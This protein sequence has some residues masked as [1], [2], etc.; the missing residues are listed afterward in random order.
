[1]K[2]THVLTSLVCLLFITACSNFTVDSDYTPET[3]FDA[4]KTYS[5]Y[6]AKLRDPQSLD[7]LGGDIFDKRVRYNID[8]QLQAKGFVLKTEGE[9]DFKVNYDVLT[10]DRQDIRTYNTYGGMAPG[11][12]YHGGYGYGGMNMGMGTSQTQVVNYKQGQLIIDIILPQ[13][14]VLVWRGTAE[15][16]IPKNEKP[17]KREKG[18]QQLIA[19]ILS[20]FPPKKK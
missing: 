14:E 16:R 1:M 20:N 4:F 7:L 12:G 5:W 13:D 15:G 10:E 18:T 6:S 8:Q 9:V 19:Q 17:E 3:D 2:L 11:F